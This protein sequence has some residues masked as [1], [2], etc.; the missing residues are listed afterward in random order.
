VSNYSPALMLIGHGSRSQAGVRQFWDFAAV[1][2]DEATGVEVAC[3]LIEFANPT[4]D[5]AI[6]SLVTGGA[7]AVVAVPL[8]LLGAGHMKDDGPA[9]LARARKRHPEVDFSYARDLGVHPTVLALVERRVHEALQRRPLRGPAETAVVIV[10]RGST[11]PDAN[12]DL[13]KAG[14]L[15]AD[16]RHLTSPGELDEVQP[17][18]VSLAKPSVAEALDRVATLGAQRIAVVPYFL[19]T[20]LLVDR[21]TT[22]A[23]EWAAGHRDIDVSVGKEIG[24]D[25]ALAR[26]V[27]ER[28]EEAAYGTVVMNCDACCY[29]SQLPGYEDRLGAPRPLG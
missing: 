23:L 25:R 1:L 14:R 22:Q 24:A 20:G 26:L 6:D 21:L 28:F 10:G 19:F 13:Y 5:Q 9:A 18:F 17:A 15:L 29:R 2:R 4:L 11:D 27:V 7:T 8:V 16:R 12:A 3:G